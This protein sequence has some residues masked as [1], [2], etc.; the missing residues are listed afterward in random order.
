MRRF[1]WG[2]MV[3][4]TMLALV[5]LSAACCCPLTGLGEVS[6]V[7]ETVEAA[8]TEMPTVPP[9]ALETVAALMTEIP[10]TLTALPPLTIQPPGGGETVPRGDIA[11]GETVHGRLSSADVTDVWLLTLPEPAIVVVDLVA[12]GDAWDPLLQVWEVG[13]GQI[14][15]DDDSG[16]GFNAHLSQFFAAGTYEVQVLA[17]FSDSGDYTLS[18]HSLQAR[19]VRYGETISGHLTERIREEWWMLEGQAGDEVTISMVGL[20]D[21]HDTYL[22]LYGPDGTVLTNDDDSGEGFF[23]LIEHFHLPETGTYYIIARAWGSDTGQYELT[24]TGP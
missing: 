6:E 7:L 3:A 15:Y 16:P 24:L 8:M 9:G 14:A 11:V 2:M 4:L 1:V 19:P 20:G 5:A 17:V 22:E 13:G 12:D 21:F 18:V 23:A 10:T